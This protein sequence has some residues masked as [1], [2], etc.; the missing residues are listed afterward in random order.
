MTNTRDPKVNF[1]RRAII[2]GADALHSVTNPLQRFT[3]GI[4][5][6]GGDFF[7]KTRSQ[8]NPETLEQEQSDGAVIRS[9]FQR[10]NEMN[11]FRYSIIFLTSFL[12]SCAV[13]NTYDYS[14]ASVDLAVQGHSELGLAVI[15][16]RPYILS[17]DK[18]PNFVGLQRGGF[19]NPFNVRTQ[20]GRA[21]AIE[22]AEAMATE[23]EDNGFKVFNLGVS[24]S[25]SKIIASAIREAS[26]TRNVILE[27]HE[28]KTDAMISF[29]L[30]YDLRLRV[31]DDSANLLAETE[32]S[33]IKEKLGGAGF[34]G[35]NSISAANAFSSK[36]GQ[37]F[38]DPDVMR[39]L[40]DGN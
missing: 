8:W 16:Q 25:G 27:V 37:L 35:S 31:M 22:M 4:H 6:Y 24:E 26:K 29:G 1:Q 21:L 23:L 19:G 3:G 5:I 10:E 20:S 7:D 34:E 40:N 30:S 2:A 18:E 38:N 28:W 15:D 9:M 17:G 13:G 14:R 36:L 32:T 11:I 33:G 39:A 12:V